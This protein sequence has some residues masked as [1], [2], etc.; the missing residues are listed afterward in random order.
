MDTTK[1]INK[2]IDTYFK[3]DS[4]LFFKNSEINSE[5]KNKSGIYV[6]EQPLFSDKLGYPIYKIGYAKHSLYTRISNYRTAYGLIPFKI[7]ALY[8][9]PN[10]VRNKQVNYAHLQER[11]VQETL[12][13]MGDYTETGEWF[14]NIENITS[15]FTSLRAKHL[16]EIKSRNK[17]IFLL[18]NVRVLRSLKSRQIYLEDESVVQ[19]KFKDLIYQGGVQTRKMIEE[20]YDNEFERY[21][22][23]N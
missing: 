19:S 9:V 17:W 1:T 14:K 6:I 18:P 4:R 16:N 10:G 12:Q 8:C 7:H 20:E 11:V 22:K 5:F 3:M 2:K 23:R 21:A 15:V 13:I